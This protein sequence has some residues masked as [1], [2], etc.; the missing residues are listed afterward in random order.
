MS[1]S[2]GAIATE[3]CPWTL[4][5]GTVSFLTSYDGLS[6]LRPS[7]SQ[8][9]VRNRRV[10][11]SGR[12]YVVWESISGLNISP[13]GLGSRPTIPTDPWDRWVEMATTMDNI[14]SVTVT[15]YK[16]LIRLDPLV[17]CYK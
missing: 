8:Q 10:A 16:L 15:W 9:Y 1:S 17:E 12:M 3:E 2:G 5:T 11:R 7:Y 14:I 6:H 4:E 13:E